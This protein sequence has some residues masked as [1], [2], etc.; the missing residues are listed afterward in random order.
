[1][2]VSAADLHLRED[3]LACLPEVR[4]DAHHSYRQIIDYCIKHEAKALVLAG[5]VFDGQPSSLDVYVFLEGVMNLKAHD[6]AVYAIQGQHGHSRFSWANVHPHV[7]DLN[8]VNEPHEIEPGVFIDGYDI[9]P[10]DELQ[11]ALKKVK[12]QTNVLALH[13]M[14]K[15]C[16]PDIAGHQTWDYDPE[17]CPSN[18]ALVLLGDYHDQWQTTTNG[19]KTFQIYNGSTHMR[20]INE[21]PDKRFLRVDYDKDGGFTVTPIALAT[22]VFV[23][24]TANDR[25]QAE[26]LYKVIAE[27]PEQTL[28]RLNYDGDIEGFEE[29][30]RAAGPKVHFYF[31]RFSKE[32]VNPDTYDVDKL[33]EIS[34]RGCLDQMVDRE[35]D[36]EFHGFATALLGA[37]NPEEVL[38]VYKVK[39]TGAACESKE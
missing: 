32:A 37:E 5:D 17:W 20:A 14:A 36:A 6:I 19:G 29:A 2:F 22:R 38:E 24:R 33:R 16:M 21:R 12:K 18:V 4:G 10:P 7:I 39:L 30:C 1:M 9:L 34:L 13:Q 23:E 27:F 8:L 35:K 26:A 15:G 25:E 28:A 11:R 31:R 3:F